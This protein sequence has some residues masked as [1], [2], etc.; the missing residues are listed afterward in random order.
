MHKEGYFDYVRLRT[1]KQVFK[2]GKK[3]ITL[4]YLDSLCSFHGRVVDVKV[5]EC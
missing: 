2:V 4:L 3:C 1:E 5:G